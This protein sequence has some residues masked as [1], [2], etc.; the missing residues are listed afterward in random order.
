MSGPEPLVRVRE[1]VKYF[2]VRRGVIR[3][4]VGAVKA[5]DGVSFHIREGETFALV[6]ESGS[7]KSTTGRALLQLVRPTSGRVAFAGTELTGLAGE[8]LRRAR[9]DMQMVFQ[10]PYASLNPRLT[11]GAGVR[12]PLD[13]HAIGTASERPA[14]VTELLGLVGLDPGLANRYPHELSGGQRQRVGIARALATGPRFLVADEPI[15]ALDVSIQAQIVNLLADLRADLGLTYLFIA[16]DLAVVHHLSDRVAVMYLGRIVELGPRDEVFARPLHPYTRALLDAVPRGRSPEAGTPQV[17]PAAEM[18]DA[19]CLPVG[20]RYHPRCPFATSRCR[21]EDP[22]PRDLSNGG[23]AHIVAC[24]HAGTSL[25]SSAGTPPPSRG[26][27]GSP[28]I[29]A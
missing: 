28:E 9:R 4:R 24:H 23:E 11:V 6:G 1:L 14:R 2:P 19:A 8:R 15:S 13:V 26:G 3:R 10:D 22:R 12:E 20:C 25:V 17:A 27:I 29:E 21:S 5:V 16:H 7:G 18:P